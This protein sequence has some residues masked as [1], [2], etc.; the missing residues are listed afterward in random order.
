MR[1]FDHKRGRQLV[2][3]TT[4]EDTVAEE[5]AVKE[6]MPSDTESNTSFNNSSVRT[7]KIFI[8]NLSEKTTSSDIR[9]LFEKY[10]K[11]VECDVMKNFG[12]VHMDDDTTGRAAIKALNGSMVNDLAM[13]VEAATSRRGPNT[14]T[15]KIFVGNLSETTKANEVRE[16]FGRYGTVVECD[17]VRTY[18]FVHI[19]STDVSRLIKDLNGHMLDGQPIKVQISNS[20]VRQRPGMGMPEQCYRCGKGGHWSRECSREG[21]GY[22]RDALP[23]LPPPRALLYPPPPPPSFVRD[24]ILGSYG[25]GLKTDMT[26]MDDYSMLSHSEL[27]GHMYETEGLYDRY[28]DRSLMRTAADGYGMDRRMPRMPSSRDYLSSSTRI[29]TTMRD[30]DY[31]FTRRSPLSSSRTSSSHA[32]D[33]FSRDSYDDRRVS[34]SR[35]S[36]RYTPY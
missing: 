23:P 5:T 4:E 20:R 7:F 26:R 9:P 2:D 24:R 27:G 18:G 3:C 13:K 19:D 14:P 32:Y 16:L 34:G 6:K 36:S 33:D 28:Y 17:I 35:G 1:D 21:Y 25:T 29:G 15:T 31:V 12:F 30:Q 11:V 8:G 22:G 10:G